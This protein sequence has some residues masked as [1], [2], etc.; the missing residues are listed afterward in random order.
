MKDEADQD[1]W[2]VSVVELVGGGSVIIKATPSSNQTPAKPVDYIIWLVC[3]TFP[4][5]CLRRRQAQT[6][7][8]IGTS[9]KI[10]YVSKP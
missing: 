4:Q 10:D 3:N 1:I 7:G 8:D 5:L 9:H 2:G 6:V